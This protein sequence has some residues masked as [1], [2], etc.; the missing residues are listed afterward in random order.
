MN[1]EPIWT[2]S[3]ISLFLTN[4]SVFIVFYGLV[5][6]LPLYAKDALSRTDEEAGLLMTIF[7]LSAIIVRP[8]T[9]KLLDIAGKRRMLW[10]SLIF[11]LICTVLYYFITPFE[12]LLALRFF[13]GIWFS[14]VTTA[15]GSIAADIVPVTRRGAGLGYFVMS[16]NLAV[17]VG[18]F[19]ALFII[20]TYSYDAL[21]I[22]MSILMLIGA[23]VAVLIPDVKVEGAVTP[24]KRFTWNDLFEKKAI[25]IA[26]LASL[27]AFSYASV[28]SYLSIYALEKELLAFASFFFVVF[29]AVMLI[30][31]P[32]TGK[33]FDEKGP[34]YIL[35]P[36]FILFFIGFFILAFMNSAGLFLLAGAC[37]GLGY[38]ALVPSLQTLAIQS[39][40]HNRSGYATATFFTLFDTGLAIG[41]FI[42]GVIAS[43]FGYQNVYLLSGLLVLVVLALYIMTFRKRRVN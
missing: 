36:G 13:Q 12:G 19:I 1:K 34:V 23:V 21:F 8:F 40:S 5:S 29:A 37:V 7:L 25:P 39:T 4:L 38:G 15:A 24:S 11:Y 41:S 22:L 31:R 6:T 28:L 42:L 18:P 17:V 30:T 10:I 27:I 43:Q 26:L 16:T 9:G 3:F 33:I 20:Q 32:L 35:I 14:I 2:K